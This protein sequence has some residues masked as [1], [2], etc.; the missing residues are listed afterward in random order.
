MYDR[1]PDGFVTLHKPRES[2]LIKVIRVL[3]LLLAWV[4]FLRW[5]GL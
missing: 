4:M 2:I 1:D 3:V 5:A